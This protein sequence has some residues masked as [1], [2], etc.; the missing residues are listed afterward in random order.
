MESVECD[1]YS[2]LFPS[3]ACSSAQ[4]GGILASTSPGDTANLVRFQPPSTGQSLTIA[5]V[6]KRLKSDT[7]SVVP[8]LVGTNIV[9][10]SNLD[11][12][13]QVIAGGS[14][15]PWRKVD[16]F[17]EGLMYG[18]ICIS[19]F[20]SLMVNIQ[21]IRTQCSLRGRGELAK[22]SAYHKS[23]IQSLYVSTSGVA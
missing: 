20:E 19:Q 15:S 11:V 13:K 9:V 16:E 12:A 18:F 10:T 23:C 22:T 14:K 17:G 3:Q 2:R 6:Y 21:S 8:F 4:D 7:I 1:L 5:V